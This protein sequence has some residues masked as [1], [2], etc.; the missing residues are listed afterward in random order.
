MCYLDLLFSTCWM[1][2]VNRFLFPRLF[3][4]YAVFF[5]EE[6]NLGHHNNAVH[7]RNW[8]KGVSFRSSFLGLKK[9][10][11]EYWMG[12]FSM[13]RSTEFSMGPAYSSD[14]IRGPDQFR[15]KENSLPAWKHRI[16]L[17]VFES[18]PNRFPYLYD[19]VFLLK[20]TISDC[21]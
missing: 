9:G 6:E 17:Q 14:V 2:V 21:I 16:F 1:F 13:N 19:S 11:R 3:A 12:S 18:S 10:H 5:R 4:P 8:S 20:A 15:E 7:A